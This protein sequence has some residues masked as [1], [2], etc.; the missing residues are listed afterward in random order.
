MGKQG[1]AEIQ[2]TMP[3]LPDEKLQK[4]VSDIGMRIAKGSERPNLP[5]SFTVIDDAT[6]NA[7]ALPGGPIF[8]TRGILTHMN[9]EAELASVLGH[10]VGH[11]TARHSVQ[12][13]S[14][15]QLAQIGLGV[16]SV[17]SPE[18]AAAGQVA[19]AGLQLLFLKYGRDAERQS[20]EL[21]FKYMVK[22]G[23]DPHEMPK[24]FATLERVSEGGGGG[25]GLPGFLSTHPDPG[26]RKEV[27]QRRAAEVK[28]PNLKAGREEFLAMTSGLPFGE[29][30][31]QGY[32][33]GNAF[34][35]PELKFK[36]DFPQGWK[37]QNGASAVLAMSPKEDAMLQ[38]ALAGKESPQE[39][40]KKFL[41]QK[42]IQAG[43]PSAGQLSGLPAASSYFQAQTEKGTVAGLVTFVSHGGMTFG[44][45]GYTGAK[46]LQA[47]DAAFKQTMQSFGPLTDPA[48]LAVQPAR[49]EVVKVPR[50]MTIAEFNQQFPSTAPI[51]QV[52]ILNGLDQKGTLKAGQ[53]AKRVVG[54]PPAQPQAAK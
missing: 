28:A 32:F 3:R 47:H 51:E 30:P 43:G 13:I 37:T 49:I 29:N 34:L 42:G 23:W 2:A 48:A 38:L 8:V 19:G 18:L 31:R 20:D 22:Q 41:S 7:F 33:K 12:Q 25:G 44:I 16:G 45:L 21:G 24:M 14:K 26:D 10:E 52:A 17:I 50:D 4:Y 15:A 5:W 46:S 53:S 35:H 36:I 6:V 54:G 39:A 40:A 1:A 11:V 9:S 27:A